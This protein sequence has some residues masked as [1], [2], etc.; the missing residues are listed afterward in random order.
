MI[1]RVCRR[2]PAAAAGVCLLLWNCLPATCHA[3]EGPYFVTYDQHMEEPG[4]LEI[5]LEPTITRPS[6]GNRAYSGLTELEYGTAAWWTTELYLEGQSTVND[7]TLFSGFRIENRF[8]VL[9]TEHWIN[10]VLYVEYEDIS[11]A[12]KAIKEVVGFDSQ[13]D[14]LVPN[15]L[16]RREIQHEVETKLILGSDYKGWNVAENFIAEKN[17]AHAPWEFGY[18]LGM[19]RPLALAASPEWCNLCGENLRAGFE[20][21]GGLGTANDL[22]LRGTSHYAAPILA[23]SLPNGTT[24]RVSPGFGLTPNAYRFILR[25]GVN[26]EV[27]GFG[28]KVRQFFQSH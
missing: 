14:G 24:F 6:G 18:A 2:L 1:V 22:T 12:D 27:P 26:Y 4:N 21:Y 5:E 17:L 15:G 7:S 20:F 25:L 13:S 23:W 9:P 3:Q 16:A 28:R 10:P 8:H 11:G 19:N